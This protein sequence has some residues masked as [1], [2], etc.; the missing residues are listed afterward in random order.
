MKSNRDVL[1]QVD[2]GLNSKTV[3]QVTDAGADVIVAAT[4]I[5]GHPN[6]ISAGVNE[7]RQSI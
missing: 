5:F 6:G 2:G 3:K 1:I 7:L 4:A